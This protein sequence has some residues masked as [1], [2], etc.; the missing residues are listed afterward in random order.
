MVYKINYSDITKNPI[1]VNDGSLDNS[2]DLT[3][4]GKSYQGG[5]GDIVAENFIHLL[6]NFAKP[7]PP[8]R[9]VEGQLWY[10]SQNGQLMVYT[11]NGVWKTTSGVIVSENAPT[12]G[13]SQTDGDLWLDTN[14]QQIYMFYQ[15]NWNNIGNTDQSTRQYSNTRM[16]IDGI[17]HKTL[18]LVV[19]NKTVAVFSSSINNWIPN[20]SGT[21]I[22]RLADNSIMVLTYPVIRPGLNLYNRKN[23]PE[24]TVNV[25]PPNVSPENVRIGDFWYA[26]STKEFFI[27]REQNVWDKISYDVKLDEVNPT[28]TTNYLPGQFWVNKT[29]NNLFVFDG[30]S[31][32]KLSEMTPTTKIISKTRLDTNGQS[33]EVLETI[34]EGKTVSI[35]STTDLFWNPATTE[36]LEDGSQMSIYFPRIGSGKNYLIDTSYINYDPETNSVTGAAPGQVPIIRGLA[37]RARYTGSYESRSNTIE[38]APSVDTENY[39]YQDIATITYN[40]NNKQDIPILFIDFTA[41]CYYNDVLNYSIRL[42]RLQ[43][44]GINEIG[45]RPGINATT[46]ETIE[47]GILQWSR[48]VLDIPNFIYTVPEPTV[49]V[50]YVLEAAFVPL[51]EATSSNFTIFGTQL[52]ISRFAIG[53]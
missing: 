11:V 32:I 33:H 48:R 4:I 12:V 36:L 47:D 18:E 7:T 6:E 16:D 39:V 27:Y 2:T 8:D 43:G 17:Y 25:Y 26:T 30:T 46:S 10:D 42:K 37:E 44:G 50:E 45:N 34:I 24:V 51:P 22:E 28:N 52:N 9:P 53:V 31:W 20:S 49:E 14:T 3:L 21:T 35:D 41:N 13:L 1:L 19:D 38:I 15:N 5:F 29:T 23:L 40:I